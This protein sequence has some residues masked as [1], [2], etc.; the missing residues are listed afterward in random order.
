MLKTNFVKTN[1]ETDVT[2]FAIAVRHEL[3]KMSIQYNNVAIARKAVVAT[4]E[5]GTYSDSK[6]QEATLA[7]EELEEEN[8]KLQTLVD[9]TKDTWASVL[10]DMVKPNEKGF[11]NNA[12]VV[13][14][15]FR[16]LACAENS[17]L[18]KYAIIPT[19]Q[20]PA[21]YEAMEEIHVTS[22]VGTDGHTIYNKDA[23]K[24]ASEELDKIMRDSFSLPVETA[25]TKVVRVKLNSTDRNILHNIYVKGFKN[26][27]TKSKK[28]DDITFNGR[29]I[30]TACKVNKDGSVDYTGLAND[31]AKIVI[32][33]YAK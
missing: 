26:D 3:A 21:L 17:K 29:T 20:S 27:F 30:N 9:E 15:V 16:V 6:V 31:I 18:Y 4:N 24:K 5:K 33:K 23:Y 7:M 1:N 22:K 32:G 10:C 12:Q 25:Y 28:T 8:G 13:R 14:T 11:A 19:F 2:N